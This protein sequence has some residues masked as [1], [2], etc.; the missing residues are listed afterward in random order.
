MNRI[1]RRKLLGLCAATTVGL[2]GCLGADDTGNG[3]GTENGTE[4]GN[5]TDPVDDNRLE[6]DGTVVLIENDEI[7]LEEL[8]DA[9]GV[10][11]EAGFGQD[12]VLEAVGDSISPTA[13]IYRVYAD[14]ELDDPFSDETTLGTVQAGDVV[15]TV[16]SWDEGPADLENAIIED[17][18]LLQQDPNDQMVAEFE[19][20]IDATIGQMQVRPAD[21]M[22]T[23]AEVILDQPG[24]T[25][26]FFVD[27]EG[28]EQG[29]PAGAQ[30][31]DIYE[32]GTYSL[33][34]DSDANVDPPSEGIVA[35]DG[36]DFYAGSELSIRD[37]GG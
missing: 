37:R 8:G 6:A 34:V 32:P 5:D 17:G 24:A 9:E 19:L 23:E 35:L 28:G 21:E 27:P 29:R 31:V 22:G 14:A 20:E 1:G 3:D 11:I 2:A 18:V 7:V 13:G 4:D 36:I 10:R 33:I 26:G 12:P 16:E 15:Y 25:Y 30:I